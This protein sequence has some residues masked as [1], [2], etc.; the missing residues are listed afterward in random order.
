MGAQP[1][2]AFTRASSCGISEKV[3]PEVGAIF[4]Q[5]CS[6][7]IPYRA[8]QNKDKL[9]SD[10]TLVIYDAFC[11]TMIFCRSLVKEVEFWASKG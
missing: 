9:R 10:A 11:N 8:A 5:C 2:E 6:G 3:L 4:A 1:Y 7:A